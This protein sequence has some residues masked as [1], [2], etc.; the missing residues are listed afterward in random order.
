[1]KKIVTLASAAALAFGS[2]APVLSQSATNS[3]PFVSTQS[4]EGDF[5]TIGGVQYVVLAVVATGL[6]IALAD[7][8]STTTSFVPSP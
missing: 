2:A 7:G 5:L 3:D 8:S 4:Q 1:M 6:I